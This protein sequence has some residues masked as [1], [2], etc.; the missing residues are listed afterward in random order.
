MRNLKLTIEYDGT[1]YSG[2]Q[3]Q[4]REQRTESSLPWRAQ[5]ASQGRQKKTIQETIEK[6]LAKILQ[7]KVG[8]IG[9]GRTDAG[10]HAHGQVANFK[11][12]SKLDCTNIQ[13]GL[14]SILPCDIRIKHIEE[15][16]LD[17]HARFSAQSKLYRYTI[18][19]QTF[20]PPHSRHFSYLV[21]YP[22]DEKKIAQ[23]ARYLLGR[24]NLRSFQAKDKKERSA[25]RT[26]KRL[27][28]RRQGNNIY[29]E[30]EADG[31]LYRMVRNIVGTLIE[32]GRGKLK[33]KEIKGILK[34]KNRIYA[35]PCAP[36]KGLCLMAVKYRA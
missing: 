35:G 7:E 36:A 18:V 17:F 21:K 34:A 13:A 26:I 33:P 11:T 2:W 14:N 19:N 31:F 23:A 28:I 12:K 4:N 25:L 15:V 6:A 8:V 32:I 30:I 3:I 24:H 27:N 9:S 10:A 1:N 29:L 20:L 16:P 22:L 5:P